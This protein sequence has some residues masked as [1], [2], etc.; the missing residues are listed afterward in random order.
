LL[1]SSASSDG[2]VTARTLSDDHTDGRLLTGSLI[3]SHLN[4]S[5]YENMEFMSG[6]VAVTTFDGKNVIPKKNVPNNVPRTT[7]TTTAARILPEQLFADIQPGLLLTRSRLVSPT[8]LESSQQKQASKFGS[9][10]VMTVGG[11]KEKF[12]VTNV[13]NTYTVITK[14]QEAKYK[15]CADQIASLNE[16]LSKNK[17]TSNPESRILYAAAMAHVPALAHERASHFIGLANCAFLSA[18]GITYSP[19]Q[20][21]KTPWTRL[22]T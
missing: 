3:E 7:E 10:Q 4:H 19:D 1:S 2:T 14:S 20:V 22:S 5:C 15:H 16:Y 8:N 11:V 13:P 18:A 6:Q 17:H 9:Q 21:M 12:D